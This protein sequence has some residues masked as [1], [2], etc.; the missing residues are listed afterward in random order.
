MLDG[1]VMRMKIDPSSGRPAS[2]SYRGRGPEG[3]F[4]DVVIAFSDYR[5]TGGVAVPF[6]RAT[7]FNGEAVPSQSVTL[8]SADVDKPI[9]DTRFKR[10]SS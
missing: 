3:D 4:G 6:R 7:T 5:D 1:P 2:V 10:P 8:Q 9:D